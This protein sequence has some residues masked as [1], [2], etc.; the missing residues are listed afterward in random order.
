MVLSVFTLTITE[1]E[2][3]I[4]LASDTHGH[5]LGKWS[6]DSPPGNESERVLKIKESLPGLFRSAP[7]IHPDPGHPWPVWLRLSLG[8]LW[9]A[10]IS[11]PL[12]Q[13][14]PRSEPRRCLEG[15][16]ANR[17]FHPSLV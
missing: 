17:V 4:Q 8:I 15:Y 2:S 13:V 12:D 7:L 14:F 3:Q 16:N 5:H 10:G 11:V 1:M 6:L 9:S